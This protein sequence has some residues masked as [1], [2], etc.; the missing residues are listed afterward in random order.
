[1]QPK[2]R[3]TFRFD[4]TVPGRAVTEA[5]PADQAPAS[6]ERAMESPYQE[7]IQ[8][9]EEMIRGT[10]RAPVSGFSKR[11]DEVG[12]KRREEG[13][14]VAPSTLQPSAAATAVPV[15]SPTGVTPVPVQSSSGVTRLPV[16]TPSRAAPE[17][18]HQPLL[19][20]PSA[21]PERRSNQASTHQA[22]AAARDPRIVDSVHAAKDTYG[23]LNQKDKRP[24]GQTIPFPGANRR[25]E[26]EDEFYANGKGRDGSDDR[27]DDDVLYEG[28]EELEHGW[29][30]NERYGRGD[31]PSWLRVVVTVIG[32]IATGGLFGYLLLTLFTGEPMIPKIGGADGGALPAAVAPYGDTASGSESTDGGVTSLANGGSAAEG[33]AS[34]GSGQQAASG[35]AVA[36]PGLSL[37]VLQYGVFKTEASMNEAIQ[38]LRDKGIAASSDRS[39]GDYRVYAGIS[40]SKAEADSLVSSLGGTEVY[41]K[42][43]ASDDLSLASSG[44]SAEYAAYLK[45]SSSLIGRIA[46]FTA[47]S[48]TGSAP[49]A[50][51]DI[52]SIR[53][54][55]Q[56]WLEQSKKADGWEGAAK[57]SAQAEIEQLSS[58]VNAL[59]DYSDEPSA[60]ELWSAQAAAMNAALADLQL[61]EAVQGG[62]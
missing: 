10:D 21:S 17:P 40:P 9:L 50:G 20:V 23:W 46:G 56:V 22:P 44:R 54:A 15:Q 38:Q 45:A 31:G 18:I 55:H 32:A 2:A 8:A 59:N 3:M 39:A 37:Y 60:A 61:R 33:Q 41:V 53:T 13:F 36:V 42:A 11:T 51:D 14:A 29:I 48:L 26:R 25:N 6:D 5:R 19:E 52:Q 49:S 4:G 57:Q 12:A 7:D 24:T 30:S 43:F 1:M 47:A 34:Q 58:A 35:Q 27:F 62:N 28:P 16:R